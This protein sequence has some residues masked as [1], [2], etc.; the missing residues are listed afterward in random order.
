MQIQ[1]RMANESFTLPV[2]ACQ[3]CIGAAIMDRAMRQQSHA[4]PSCG[5]MT[6]SQAALR[7]KTL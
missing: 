2:K 1:S 6:S 5:E 4:K 3:P 7:T